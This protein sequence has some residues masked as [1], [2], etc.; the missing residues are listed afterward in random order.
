M[1]SKK[2]IYMA[3][4]KAIEYVAQRA[5]TKAN[6]TEFKTAMYKYMNEERSPGDEIL[7]PYTERMLFRKAFVKP[8]IYF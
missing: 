4:K 3:R 2:Q 1:S 7:L 8:L 5:L 6:A